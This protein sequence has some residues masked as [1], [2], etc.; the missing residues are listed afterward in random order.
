[1]S[2]LNIVALIFNQNF[3]FIAGLGINYVILGMTEGILQSTG[4]DLKLWAYI[5]TILISGIFLLIWKKSKEEN[6]AIYLIGLIVYGL[7]TIIFIFAKDWLSL[8]FHVFALLMLTNGY[9]AL[10]TKKRGKNKL[11]ST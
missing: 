7:D 4:I 10:I 11:I 3:Q 9:N 2:A 5:F 6:K 8:G 1:L